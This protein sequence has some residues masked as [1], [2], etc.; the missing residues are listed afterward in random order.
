MEYSV[1]DDSSTDSGNYYSS[2]SWF[3]KESVERATVMVVGAGALGNEVIKNLVLFGIERIVVVDFD[4]VVSSNLTRSILFNASDADRSIAKVEAIEREI[5][6]INPRARVDAIYGDITSD[7]GLGLFRRMSVVIGC[8]DNRW[9]RFIINRFCMRANIG[10]VD[11]GI[12]GLEGSARVFLAGKNCY[13]CNL[14]EQGLKEM[15]RRISCSSIVRHNI[16]QGR[17][18]TTPIIASIIGAIEVQEAMKLIHTGLL[19]EGRLTS[20]CGKMI[21]WE[22]E[23]LTSK[24]VSFSGYDDD[25]PEHE[26]WCDIVETPLGCESSVEE[27]FSYAREHLDIDE[28]HI[29]LRD[30]TFI[31]SISHRGSDINI[32]VDLPSYKVAGFVEQQSSLD[33]VA[34]GDIDLN[35]HR[36]IY[37]GS[38]F[39]K[40]KLCEIGFAKLSVVVVR[41]PRGVCYLELS[42][43]REHYSTLK[44]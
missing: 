26:Q 35:E 9:A 42:R 6:R 24:I 22:G 4:H 11:G 16:E 2:L 36:K 27:L 12:D 43:D 37:S 38:R 20:L 15:S 29:T 19:E 32:K 8:V 40:M 39:S 7:V 17:V 3:D 18:A 21:Y 23:H 1:I 41:T 25:C 31:E 33:S 5:K 10:W 30:F 44:E 34:I 13:A 14:G 28:C